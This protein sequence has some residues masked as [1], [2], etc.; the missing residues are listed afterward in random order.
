MAELGARWIVA[1]GKTKSKI[2]AS[3]YKRMRLSQF[4]LPKGGEISRLLAWKP[5]SNVYRGILANEICLGQ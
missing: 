3:R 5:F 2:L 1:G 4:Y